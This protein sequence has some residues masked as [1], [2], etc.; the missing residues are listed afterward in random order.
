MK[1]VE[2]SADLHAPCMDDSEHRRRCCWRCGFAQPEPCLQAAM[3]GYGL[4][5]ILTSRNAAGAE[6]G[7]SAQG[8]HSLGASLEA[9]DKAAANNGA[10]SASSRA[11]VRMPASTG[12]IPSPI[13]SANQT[14]S[15]SRGSATR[16]AKYPAQ[17]AL[18]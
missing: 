13:P 2:L 1:G 3:A 8:G 12:G 11:T 18:L 14:A 4:G 5:R 6:S 16:Q 9:G 7:S 15:V 10:R 17:T